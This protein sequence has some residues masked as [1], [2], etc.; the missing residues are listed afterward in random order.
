MRSLKS[1]LSTSNRDPCPKYSANDED[2]SR[3]STTLARG[4]KSVLHNAL[5]RNILGR[6][7]KKSLII[8][9]M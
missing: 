6:V 9:F 2:D 5:L 8:G 4:I 1:K 7:A 3:K